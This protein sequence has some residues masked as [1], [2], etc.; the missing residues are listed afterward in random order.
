MSVF[1]DTLDDFY[2]SSNYTN[3]TDIDENSSEDDIGLYIFMGIMFCGLIC[4]FGRPFFRDFLKCITCYSLRQKIKDRFERWRN[5]RRERQHRA[6]QRDINRNN[7]ENA[8][9]YSN[10]SNESENENYY[11]NAFDEPDDY[12][13]VVIQKQN[14]ITPTNDDCPICLELVNDDD[15]DVIKLDCT[16]QYHQ[17]CL[18]PWIENQLSISTKS[19]CPLC[20]DDI[21]YQKLK[22]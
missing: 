9:R 8:R 6:I 18:M 7:I 17:P 12:I 15:K 19:S 20:R 1:N 2:N 11:N 5:T 14:S 13:V 22:K 10:I 3:T 4:I 21:N 16:H